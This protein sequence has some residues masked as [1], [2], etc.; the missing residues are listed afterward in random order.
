MKR[1]KEKKLNE[2]ISRLTPQDISTLGNLLFA[3]EYKVKNNPEI[4]SPKEYKMQLSNIQ[5]ITRLLD[6][7]KSIG[8]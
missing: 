6:R 8:Y 1:Y 5:S 7:F 2:K 4:F 3:L